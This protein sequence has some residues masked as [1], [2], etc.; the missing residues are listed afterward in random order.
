MLLLFYIICHLSE[1]SSYHCYLQFLILA[2]CLHFSWFEAGYR[3]RR[4]LASSP[5]SVVSSSPASCSFSGVCSCSYACMLWSVPWRLSRSW[6]S[7]QIKSGGVTTG[8][9]SDSYRLS[10]PCLSGGLSHLHM[11]CLLGWKWASVIW[12]TRSG[13]PVP[14]WWDSWVSGVLGSSSLQLFSSSWRGWGNSLFGN[15][16]VIRMIPS[17]TTLYSD[18]VNHLQSKLNLCL[19]LG[20]SLNL[21]LE[22]LKGSL[23]AVCLCTKHMIAKII[24]KGKFKVEQD[25]PSTLCP[26][27]VW[28]PLV[29]YSHL[30]ANKLSDQEKY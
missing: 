19:Q 12:G 13:T 14:D 17:I 25:E 9:G 1:K 16:T 4:I 8:S 24:I 28:L 29:V 7:S 20:R 2:Y 10:P 11:G 15:C 6:M 26:W 18:C 21:A 23:R 22:K 3:G 5:W 27:G 30:W